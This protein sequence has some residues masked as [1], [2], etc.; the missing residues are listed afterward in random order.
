MSMSDAKLLYLARTSTTYKASCPVFTA[1]I[2]LI[3]VTQLL[4]QSLLHNPI[5][6][7]RSRIHWSHQFWPRVSWLPCEIPHDRLYQARCALRS[8][9]WSDEDALYGH[10]DNGW[11]WWLI[12]YFVGLVDSHH[13]L[14][15]PACLRR[16]QLP[17]TSVKRIVTRW[18]EW[19]VSWM[20]RR[21]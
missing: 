20:S 17:A 3:L 16:A 2:V 7:S 8:R 21:G 11:R 19:E 4:T 12:G 10:W 9:I 18:R 1:Q 14:W 6:L 15:A 13:L 5:Y